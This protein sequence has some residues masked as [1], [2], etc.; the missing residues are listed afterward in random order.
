MN[1]FGFYVII[2][3]IML[4]LVSSLIKRVPAFDVFLEGAAEGLKSTF[5]VAPALIGLI[6]S[7]TMLKSSGALDI[8]THMILP[9]MDFLHFPAPAVP[10]ALLR[11][12]S[13]SGSIALLDNILS[14]YGADSIVGRL[15]SMIMGSTETTFYTLAVYF[16][17]VNIKNSRHAVLCA[18]A[19]D[20]TAIVVS[21]LIVNLLVQKSI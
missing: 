21:S 1:N 5:S 16:G 4:V 12:I 15:C 18:L 14:T 2:L 20:F 11:P 7:V 9:I 17:S 10:L 6:T 13:G 19:A 8:F 3:T